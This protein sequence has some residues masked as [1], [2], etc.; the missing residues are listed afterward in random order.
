M[1]VVQDEAVCI[2]HWDW[3]ETSQTVSLLTRDHGLLRAIA[4]G[5]RRPKAPYSGGVELLSRAR[6]GLILKPA[7]G[8]HLL[9][10][11][12]LVEPFGHLRRDLR[13]LHAAC[14][15]ADLCQCLVQDHDPH[16]EIY[17]ALSDALRALAEPTAAGPALLVFQWRV[18][19]HG[20]FRPVIDG[21]ADAREPLSTA[22][23]VRFSPELG[24]LVRRAGVPEDW[25]VRR[26]TLQAVHWAATGGRGAAPPAGDVDRANALLGCYVRYILGQEPRTFALL[27]PKLSGVR[28]PGPGR[29]GPG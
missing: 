2:R 11:W 28:A 14:Y 18:L 5:S 23:V 21:Y 4:K 24:G 9:T 26:A 3:S 22:G 15:M 17:D 7:S 10:E 6:V 27:F 19:V 13:A 12:D 29:G 16:P 1:P 20:G 25:P 8:L